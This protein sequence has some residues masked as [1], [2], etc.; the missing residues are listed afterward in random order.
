MK[1]RLILAIALLVVFVAPLVS[2]SAPSEPLIK[3][4]RYRLDT[5][6]VILWWIDEPHGILCSSVLMLDMSISCVP[7]SQTTYA[8]EVTE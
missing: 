1:Q 4:G 5:G 8:Q 7:L 6:H 3:T 2:H